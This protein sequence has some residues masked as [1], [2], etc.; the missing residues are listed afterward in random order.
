[1]SDEAAAIRNV[2]QQYADAVNAGDIGRYGATLANEIVFHAPDQPPMEGR[3][4]VQQWFTHSWL[5]TTNS[6]HLS[7]AIADIN[8]LGMWAVAPREV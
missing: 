2:F 1:M 5:D 3:H 6:R 4:S 7:F 8:D